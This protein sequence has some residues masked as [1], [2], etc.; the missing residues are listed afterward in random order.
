MQVFMQNI[1]YYVCPILT[2]V[3]L[4]GQ[5]V[6]K[7]DNTKFHNICSAVLQFIIY[8]KRRKDRHEKPITTVL[9]LFVAN[10]TVCKHNDTQKL[11][12]TSSI[13][14]PANMVMCKCSAMKHR[15]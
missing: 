9:Q 13:F 6:V 4:S 1:Y 5:I 15:R 7:L 11:D 2:K 14:N 8:A 12:D 3:V 10:A